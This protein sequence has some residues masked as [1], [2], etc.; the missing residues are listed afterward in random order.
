LD[1]VVESFL[2]AAGAMVVGDG[3]DADT[4]MGPLVNAAQLARFDG[5]VT[6]ARADGASVVEAGRFAADRDPDG[7][8]RLPAAVTGVG[9]SARIV[10]DEQFGPALPFVGVADDEEAVA[11]ANGTDFG[12]GASVWSADVDHARSVAA[13]IDAGMVF[14]NRHDLGA[15]HPLGAFGGTKHSGLGRE[16]GRWGIE[17]Y[18]EPS[19]IVD[20]PEEG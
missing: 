16:M 10:L 13:R 11:L 1:S 5:F 12:L 18:S 9:Q 3:L 17:S 19:Q 2:A 14:L 7:Y 8:F 4:T 20:A 15:A 6:E